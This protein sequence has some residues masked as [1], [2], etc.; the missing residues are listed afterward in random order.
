MIQF[1]SPKGGDEIT[2]RIGHNYLE[3]AVH[4]APLLSSYSTAG[5]FNR[6]CV[7][8]RAGV[9]PGRGA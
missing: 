4:R 7:P 5:F 8:I 2:P 9:S 1:D 6:Q 3:S